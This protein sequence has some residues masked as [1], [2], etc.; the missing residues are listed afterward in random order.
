MPRRGKAVVW[1]C[2]GVFGRGGSVLAVVL[3]GRKRSIFYRGFLSRQ[4]TGLLDWPRADSLQ[5]PFDTEPTIPNRVVRLAPA[6]FVKQR[7]STDVF[8]S[9]KMPIK[10][11][12]LYGIVH[13]ISSA[14]PCLLF[15][16][17]GESKSRIGKVL[18]LCRALSG[19]TCEHVVSLLQYIRFRFVVI[20]AR[21]FTLHSNVIQKKALSQTLRTGFWGTFA[22]VHKTHRFKSWDE[23]SELM[24]EIRKTHSKICQMAY[25]HS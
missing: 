1:W 2:R 13:S 16:L 8:K 15:K 18:V 11:G 12:L 23:T 10:S 14:M 25:W 4:T 5:D 20:R 19:M 7:N 17:C 22:I 6:G 9:S 24:W 3:L 21:T